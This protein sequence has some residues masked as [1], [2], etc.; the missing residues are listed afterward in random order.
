MEYKAYYVEESDGVFSS[1][2]QNL[3]IPEPQ[4]GELLISVSYSSLNYKD[5]LCATGVKGVAASYPFVPGIDAVGTVAKSNSDVFNEGDQGFVLDR[6]VAVK[7]GDST[8]LS[9]AKI[10]LTNTQ[11]GDELIYS[12]QFWDFNK[13]G[14]TI[15][16]TSNDAQIGK[17]ISIFEQ[18]IRSVQFNNTSD[19]PVTNQA[20]TITVS[21]KDLDADESVTTRDASTNQ[22][23]SKSLTFNLNVIDIL[24][25]SRPSAA[26][27]NSTCGPIFLIPFFVIF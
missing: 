4:N 25:A 15:T 17:A 16:L 13:S 1:S 11:S 6:S 26:A 7:D 3:E 21:I 5:A 19:S 12:E 8:S 22:P 23:A 9:E 24:W 20:R 18:A 10:V 14:N 27:N 2:I